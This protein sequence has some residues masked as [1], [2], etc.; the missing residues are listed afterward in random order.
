MANKRIQD[1]PAK[2]ATIAANDILE[3]SE[4]QSPGVYTSKKILGSELGGV[5]SFEDLTDTFTFAGN[6]LETVRVNAAGTA[7]E[8]YTPATAS[9]GRFGIADSSGVYTY[10]TTLT[11]AMTAATSGQT[12]EFFTDYT[13]TGAVTITLK[14]GV[15]INGNGHT[16]T[17]TSNADFK[18]F[19]DNNV[20]IKSKI[21]NLNIVRTGTGTDDSLNYILEVLNTSSVI[22][23]DGSSIQSNNTCMLIGGTVNGGY[24]SGGRVS[25]NNPT[26]VLLTGRL[27]NATLNQESVTLISG[28]TADTMMVS[29]TNVSEIINCNFNS[30]DIHCVRG[31]GLIKATN[32]YSTSSNKSAIYNDG[33]G[34]IVGCAGYSSY[35]TFENVGGGKCSNS[36]AISTG[37]YAITCGTSGVISN[38]S[39]RSAG[40]HAIYLAGAGIVQNCSAYSTAG[41]GINGGVNARFYNCSAESTVNYALYGDIIKSCN[42]VSHASITTTA[43]TY[44][45]CSIENRWNNAGGHGIAVYNG[46]DINNTVIKVTN[47]SANCLYSGSASSLKYANNVFKGAT[48]AVNANITQTIVNTHDSQGNILI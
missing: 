13:E 34:E 44:D 6:E 48:T 9:T 15:N 43:T 5:T 11:L 8:T 38:C 35:I 17:L 26:C 20:N 23:M 36:S 24:Y 42:A 7:L 12:I 25:A 14:D 37:S 3:V 45:N 29:N 47:A 31:S 16:Y 40:N 22:Y 21:Q 27:N 32:V 10:Y 41:M 18:A 30:T 28:S 4:Y 2:G 1:L 19:R 33:T 46:C 39:A